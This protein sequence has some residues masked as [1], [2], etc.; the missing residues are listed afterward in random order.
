MSK[1][2]LIGQNGRTQKIIS[3]ILNSLG[4]KIDYCN[5]IDTACQLIKIQKYVLVIAEILIFS[6]DGTE[7]EKRIFHLQEDLPILFICTLESDIKS[8][9]LTR[10]AFIS[11][12][13]NYDVFIKNV[14]QLISN[15]Y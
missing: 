6:I 15:N 2:L 3:Y 4:Y 7:I 12:P 14:E 9:N 11:M 10:Y 1:I 5:D 8:K 13:I